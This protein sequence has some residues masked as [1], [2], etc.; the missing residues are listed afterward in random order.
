L[1]KNKKAA[2]KLKRKKTQQSI[3][4]AAET[5]KPLTDEKKN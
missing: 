5:I 3:L 1:V 2:K 4:P